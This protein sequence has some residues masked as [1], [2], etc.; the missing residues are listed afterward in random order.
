[1]FAGFSPLVEALMCQYAK[2]SPYKDFAPPVF[3]LLGPDAE[4]QRQALVARYPVF[5]NGRTGAEQVIG[6]LYAM[7][8]DEHFELG[9]E[10]FVQVSHPEGK[11]VPP[12]AVLFCGA[13]DELNLRRAMNLHQQSVRFRCWPVPFHVYQ[14]RSAGTQP[15]DGLIPFGMAEQVFDLERLAAVERNARAV[16][17]A[18][19]QTML[20]ADP[21]VA[22]SSDSLKPWEQLSE[23]YR[24]A[25][26]R[27]GD[28][29]SVKLA[30]IGY[31]VEPG[32]PLV[33][34]DAIRL[35]E[36]PER[37]EWLSRLEH[38]SWR[39]ERLLNGWRYG[40]VRDNQRLLHPSMVLWE[41]LSASERQK[42]V[43]QMES[44]RQVLMA[45]Q[46]S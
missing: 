30:S 7:E 13:G 14:K 37:R 6:G 31:P 40:K 36:P 41:E 25:N 5:A 12:T 24:A 11:A 33:L 9:E 23:T 39:Y 21:G 34:D 44:V 1:V 32:K 35:D 3:T 20:A 29:F 10:Q 46:M 16:H 2:I 28:H 17:E 27:A 45:Q 4:Q 42:D 26:R 22:A 18:Y 43:S 15:G 8:C 19:R 38:R